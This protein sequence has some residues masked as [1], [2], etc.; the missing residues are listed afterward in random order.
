MKAFLLAAGHGTRLRPITDSLPKCLVPIRGEPLLKIWLDLCASFGVDEVL[1]NVH[2]QQQLVHQFLQ[3][4]ESSV[5]VRVS[6]ETEL[7]GS[8][9]TIREHSSWVGSDESF[10]IFY[11]DVLNCVD[12]GQMLRF[13]Q[14]R[15]TA[16]TIGVYRVPDPSRCGV[17]SV[18]AGGI[19]CDFVEKPA[20]PTGNLVFSGIMLA[21]PEFIKAIPEHHPVDIGSHVLPRLVGRMAAYEIKEYLMDI[22]TMTNYQAAQMTWPGKGTHAVGNHL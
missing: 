5:Q 17:V 1:I 16:A 10:W 12:L 18:D 15:R 19:V 14:A 8:A 13:H 11:A 21:T 3:D 7:L 22:G 4:Y 20:R 6:E 9:G 2:A